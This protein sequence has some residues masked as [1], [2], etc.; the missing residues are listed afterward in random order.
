MNIVNMK[1]KTNK[2]KEMWIKYVG[3]SFIVTL[4]VITFYIVMGKAWGSN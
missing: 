1:L 2:N 4:A 3:V